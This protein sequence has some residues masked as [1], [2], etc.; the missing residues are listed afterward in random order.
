V[1]DDA[2]ARINA[3]MAHF[4]SGRWAEGVEQLRSALAARPTFAEVWSNLGFGLRQLGRTDE[5][6]RA[7]ERAVALK[8]ALPDAW[9]LLGLVEQDSGRHAQAKG[10]F[11]R[12]IELRPAF[13]FAWMNRANSEQASGHLDAALD[14]YARAL[15]LAPDHPE[16]HYNLG[17][18]H[19]K[20]TGRLRE[21]LRHYREAIRLQPRYATAHHNLA[22]ALFLLGEFQEA[23]REHVWRPPRA[24][25]AASLASRGGS[26]VPPST[27]QLAGARVLI[28][29]E[30][31]LGDSLFFLRYAPLLRSA[32]A[33]LDF[34]GP[35]RLHGMLARTGL[36][37][38]LAAD[39]QSL[40]SADGHE[41]LAGDLGTLFPQV[42]GPLGLAP[43]PARVEAMHERLRALG[44]A[45][46][47]A[48]AWRAGEPKTGLFETLFKEVP[49]EVLARAVNDPRATC[50]SV[51]RDPRPGETEQLARHLGRTVHDLSA[52][53]RDLEDALALMAVVDDLAGVSHTNVHLRAGTGRP[54]RVFVPFPYEWRWMAG[55][56]SP[57]F[58]GTQVHRQAPTGEW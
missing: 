49:F 5:A 30:Q 15:A 38:R 11:A 18:L 44:P 45:P 24:L 3:G 42:P 8:P 57:W 54:S 31:G 33:T 9:N 48:L 1:A 53:N 22:H 55:G 14:A 7:L 50:V 34:A 26:Y 17:H 47:L 41:I 52:V 51:Q 56:A 37:D 43:E 19:H 36:F 39:P 46:Y 28:V 10:H 40:R 23:W 35:A 25:H 32:G 29:A 12:A 6:R 27:Q 13:A 21:A 2:Q 20:A 16:I 4:Q 58:P